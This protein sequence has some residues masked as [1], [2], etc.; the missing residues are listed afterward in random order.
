MG[1]HRFVIHSIRTE[2]RW[3]FK[4]ISFPQISSRQ[5]WQNFSRH[6]QSQRQ[7]GQEIF[8]IT[9]GRFMIK[10]GMIEKINKLSSSYCSESQSLMFANQAHA[11]PATTY[12]CRSSAKLLISNVSSVVPCRSSAKPLISNVISVVPCSY[13]QSSK[14]S[15]SLLR[16]QTGHLKS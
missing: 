15:I 5:T 3:T 13:L 2:Y 12:T 4:S 8:R 9:K 10:R 14:I 11:I 7:G 6:D 1:I 16:R